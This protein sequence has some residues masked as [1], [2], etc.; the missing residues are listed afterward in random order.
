M[1]AGGKAVWLLVCGMVIGC[2]L[3]TAE[4]QEKARASS[5]TRS[6]ASEV[7][8]I[9]LDEGPRELSSFKHLP[10]LDQGWTGDLDGMAERGYI[11]ALVVYSKTHYFLDGGRQRGLSYEALK[12]FERHLNEKLERG[13][14]KLHVAIL[15]VQ[16]DELLPAL[17]QGLG[18]IAAAN[19]T[20]TPERLELLDFSRAFGEGI[21]LGSVPF[22][23]IREGCARLASQSA[24]FRLGEPSLRAPSLLEP[25]IRRGARRFVP[26]CRR[27]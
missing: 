27:S 5:E 11:R 20:I 15:P 21:L 22:T 8:P 3:G 17:E 9:E 1:N 4:H 26:I 13:T 14:V 25:S 2:G 18:D 7:A 16:R 24:G 10:G 23:R 19:L 12:L 6:D